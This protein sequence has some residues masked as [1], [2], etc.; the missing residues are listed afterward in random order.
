MTSRKLLPP[1]SRP[2]LGSPG[3][4]GFSVYLAMIA[5]SIFEGMILTMLTST[6]AETMGL[7][8]DV[9]LCEQPM[10]G[11]LFCVIDDEMT[12]SDL[13]AFVLAVFSISVPLVI[14][15][16]VIEQR[17]I[18]EP[19]AWFAIPSNRVIAAVSLA[20]LALVCALEAVNIYTLIARQVAGG[21][22]QTVD[23]N[24][25][26]DFLANNRGLGIFVALLVTVVNI[27]VALLT[28]RA[29]HALKKSLKG[30]L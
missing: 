12:I 29:T 3:G 13:L 7:M 10:V 5:V 8:S 25:L 6:Y 18:E 16:E 22:F 27:V 26:I 21:P 11:R 1:G 19:G 24:P 4:G 20:L 15:H 28:V 9:F 14:W 17:I 23:P 30:E 2:P